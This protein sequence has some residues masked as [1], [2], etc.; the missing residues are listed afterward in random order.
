MKAPSYIFS[1]FLFFLFLLSECQAAKGGAKS[2]MGRR[3][4]QQASINTHSGYHGHQGQKNGQLEEFDGSGD[5]YDDDD[6]E[7]PC[8]GLCLL[9]K[10]LGQDPPPPVLTKPCVGKCQHRRQLGLKEQNIRKK[11]RPCVGLCYIEKLRAAKEKKRN[12][13]KK[14]KGE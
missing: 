10:K 8:I 7:T 13:E 1:S 2:M 9:M 4:H 3:K 12:E 11:K 5:N 6:I 14:N